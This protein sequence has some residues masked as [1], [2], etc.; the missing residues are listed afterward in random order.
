MCNQLHL[1][2]ASKDAGSGHVGFPDNFVTKHHIIS[3]AV[4]VHKHASDSALCLHT[5]LRATEF[6]PVASTWLR[7]DP[8]HSSRMQCFRADY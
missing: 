4:I 3:G 8:K 2:D 5:A 6:L 7:F 1:I